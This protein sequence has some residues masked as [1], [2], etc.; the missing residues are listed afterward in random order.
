M[1]TVV[2]FMFATLDLLKLD[3]YSLWFWIFF[4][5]DLSLYLFLCL[6]FYLFILLLI[7]CF[8]LLLSLLS[9]FCSTFSMIIEN[10]KVS[11]VLSLLCCL[12]MKSCCFS[13]LYWSPFDLPSLPVLLF[14]DHSD[15]FILSFNFTFLGFFDSFLFLLCLS[16]YLFNLCLLF[17]FL[18][19]DLISSF[20]RGFFDFILSF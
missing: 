9:C 8:Y 10:F 18:F 16:L 1:L 5:L 4:R 3:H 6:L 15:S 11:F 13:Y 20:F 7:V 2:V 17:V 12:C 14:L 19:F